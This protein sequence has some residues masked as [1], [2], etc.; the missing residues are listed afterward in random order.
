MKKHLSITLPIIL[1]L[2]PGLAC[3]KAASDSSAFPSTTSNNTAAQ[4]GGTNDAPVIPQS[5]AAS[6]ASRPSAADKDRLASEL[7]PLLSSYHDAAIRGDRELF[8][9]LL[10]EDFTARVGGQ[11]KDRE[12]FI[13]PSPTG[14]PNVERTEILKVQVVS[15]EGNEATVHY[16]YRDIPKDGTDGGTY[17]SSVDFVRKDGRWQMKSLIAGH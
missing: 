2:V 15:S 3:K 14:F 8:E 9:R 7:R 13:G 17:R 1:L 4:Q 12:S 5:N 10:A 16:D 6:E 11:L